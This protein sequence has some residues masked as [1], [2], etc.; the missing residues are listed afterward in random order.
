MTSTNLAKRLAL[1]VVAWCFAVSGMLAQEFT[2]GAFYHVVPASK[3]GYAVGADQ[4]GNL[5]I[6]K[7]DEANSTQH[8]TMNALSGSWRMINPFSNKAI[9]TEGNALEYGEN[10]GSDEAQLWKVENDGKFVILIPTNR[11]D[12]AA[13]LQSG[14]LVLIGKAKAKGN[15]AAHFSII[16]SET[17]G[18]DVALTYRFRSAAH[19]DLVLGN[20]DSGEN[21]A[22]IVGEKADAKN[23]GQYWSVKMISPTLRVVEGAFYSQNFDDGGDRKSVV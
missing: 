2:R 4:Q 1:S 5:T 15:K 16:P 14:N 9:R 23:R 17:Q 8:F 22:A 6:A 19:P 7:M 21:N 12:M 11:P 10:N 13:A 3:S 18:F 20:G